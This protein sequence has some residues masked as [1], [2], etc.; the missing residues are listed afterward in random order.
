[1]SRAKDEILGKIH[2]LLADELTKRLLEGE[3]TGKTNE[4]GEPVIIP[5]SAAT[6]NTIRQFLK[7]NGIT[8]TP[9]PGS[10][11]EHLSKLANWGHDDDNRFA[12]T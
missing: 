4:S 2:Q 10:P 6:L 8:A 7:D 5:A 12:L 9:M 3:A 11:L 1:V